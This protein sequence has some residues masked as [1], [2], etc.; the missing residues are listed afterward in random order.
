ME[1]EK[2]AQYLMKLKDQRIIGE[3]SDNDADE[4]FNDSYFRMETTVIQDMEADSFF[5]LRGES[6]LMNSVAS[7]ESRVSFNLN[8]MENFEMFEASMKP[9]GNAFAR[10]F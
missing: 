9:R 10:L 7:G 5:M 6:M 3:V 4:F 8:T 1:F 2:F